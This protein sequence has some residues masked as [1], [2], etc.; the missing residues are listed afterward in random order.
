MKKLFTLLLLT[1][2]SLT[3]WSQSVHWA[4]KVLESSSEKSKTDYSANQALGAPNVYPES[5]AN[6]LAWEPEGKA[7][8]EYIK[9]GFVRPVKARQIAIVETHN[10]GFVSKVYVY[11]ANGSEVE[12]KS[13]EAKAIKDKSRV[14]QINSK[15]IDF[16][17]YAVKIV[18]SN[19]LNVKVGIDAIGI[20]E[21]EKP[22][23]IKKDE[24]FLLKSNMVLTKLDSTVNSP[25]IEIGPIMSPDGKT[26]Y[27]SRRFDPGN[28]G[29]K[30]DLE[31]IYFA[32]WD[33]TQK[34]WDKA[35]NIG[36][37]L[38]NKFPNF[39]NSISP[40]G[41]T[42]LLGN[43]YSPEGSYIEDGVSISH[44]T[45]FGW[46]NPEPL[47]IE[48]DYNDNDNANY[49]L[50]NSQKILLMAIE[51]KDDTKGGL[52]IYV[53]FRNDDKTWT[54]PLNLGPNI[55]TS[56]DEI[57]AFLA[58]DDKTMYFSSNNYAG[59][60]GTDIYVTHRLDN[61]WQKWST[62]ENLGPKVN[63]SSDETYFTLS[64]SGNQA[65]FTSVGSTKDDQDM[66]SLALPPV[67]QP[68]PV[69]LVKGTVRNSKTNEPIP[70]VKIFFE[71]LESGKEVG[72]A[73]SSP[74][75]GNYEIVLPSG[76]QY[77]YLAAARGYISVGANLDLK[78][79][80][81]YSEKSIDLFLTP[82]Q[83]GE[84]IILN[85]IFFDFNK[86]ELKKES[87][88]EL[89]R[90]AKMLIENHTMQIEIGGY[91]D[92]VGS[93][94]YNDGLSEKR[95]DAVVQYLLKKSNVETSRIILKHYG[96]KNPV[97]DNSTEHGRKLNRRVEFKILA[98]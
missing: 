18:I 98:Q 25:Y 5:G 44:R 46:T 58:S 38:N 56:G 87:Y 12:I 19:P 1:V 75:S 14:L 51:R 21:S 6:P 71:D 8:E 76:A 85:N 57:Y 2:L 49:Y 83:V 28:M 23:E 81:E 52:D 78:N 86:F 43:S 65:F 16:Y 96:E 66:Y 29:G 54:K 91:T 26:L 59:F 82:A 4:F 22:I 88:N 27:F 41:N 62:P 64:A 73:S 32:K 36:A 84:K 61:T 39:I 50:S 3:A 60:G 90:L 77:G 79:Q 37:P 42:V 24:N 95:A 31:D 13:F 67:L 68:N 7:K 30:E 89:N 20:T 45:D 48:D 34:K 92:N 93:D 80:K 70:N 47:I 10:P 72:L 9:V 33:S 94:A 17:V 55:N 74:H 97:A 69:T 63:S 35:Q 15:Q 53:S 40:D 11:D